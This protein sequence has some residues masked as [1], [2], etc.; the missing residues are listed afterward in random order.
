MA[1]AKKSTGVQI[2][3]F[4]LKGQIIFRKILLKT[5]S[6]KAKEI[7]DVILQVDKDDLHG[8]MRLTSVPN[9]IIEPLRTSEP[10]STY[11]Y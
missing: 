6:H 2:F 10:T 7:G 3:P 8:A 11:V 9:S 5:K 4:I 1:F